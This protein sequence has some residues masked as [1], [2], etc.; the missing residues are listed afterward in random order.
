MT[1]EKK[2][3][4]SQP[5]EPKP[6]DAGGEEAIKR[7]PLPTREIAAAH[8]LLDDAAGKPK[9]ETEEAL[10]RATRERPADPV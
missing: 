3:I 2:T 7:Q 8:A 1:A 10:D 5:R 9:S 6:R 4:P